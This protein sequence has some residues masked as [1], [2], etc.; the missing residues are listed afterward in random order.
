[1]PE[2]IQMWDIVVVTKGKRKGA[3]GCVNGLRGKTAVVNISR[4]GRKLKEFPLKAL[5]K[6]PPV[7]LDSGQLRA[8][9]RFEVM[10][11]QLRGGNGWLKLRSEQKYIMTLD[12]LEAALAN[13]L[14]AGVPDAPTA[15]E[16]SGAEESP[17][18]AAA[19]DAAG[20]QAESDAFDWYWAVDSGLGG[21]LDSWSAQEDPAED[22]P[23]AVPGMPTDASVYGSTLYQLAMRF[24]WEVKGAAGLQDLLDGIRMHKAQREKPPLERELTRAQKE[25]FLRR[26]DNQRVQLF[27]DQTVERLYAN[28]VEQLA[29][30]GSPLA[31]EEKAYA[32]YGAG[33]AGFSEDWEASRD[34]LLRLEETHPKSFYANTLGYIYYYG[35]CNG[36]VPEY[37]KAFYWFSVGAAGG[38]FE[39]RYKISD[40]FKDGRGC[41][42][43][44]EIAAHIVWDAYN[45][46]LEYFSRGWARTKFAD[47][48]LRAGNLYRYGI[49]CTANLDRA[50]EYYLMA[51]LAIRMRRQC[52][53]YYGDASVERNIDAALAQVLPETSYAKRKDRL[54]IPARDLPR[55]LRFATGY[56]RRVRMDWRR[57]KKGS[58]RVS[59]RMQERPGVRYASKIPVLVPEAQF[60]GLQEK[61]RLVLKPGEQVCKGM[62]GKKGHVVF[63]EVSG[64][65]EEGAVLMLY[66]KK[67]AT[68]QGKIALDCRSLAGESRRYVSVSFGDPERCWDYLCDDEDVKEGTRVMVPWGDHP[69]REGAVKRVRQR[70]DC[71]ME[72]WRKA[73]KRVAKRLD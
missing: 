73:Y 35:R 4:K 3:Y 2:S 52:M 27:G 47:I 65:W 42:K 34:C 17:A 5:R 23:Q 46:N 43:D 10:P 54:K 33:H 1:M 55:L 72:L 67:V 59:F 53:D 36:G 8:L 14:A 51:K 15:Q 13:M 71:E 70:H 24:E 38:N 66:G 16:T 58:L 32:C 45:E 31:L 28:Y 12:D 19:P 41:P 11:A 63:D 39:S 40:M 48:A 68:L 6:V 18:A 9:A 21:G 20:A 29:E 62:K 26:W 57:T 22:D 7:M 56:G 25:D 30:E 44:A 69:L 49:N 50:Y 60:C 61:L 37:D 64:S